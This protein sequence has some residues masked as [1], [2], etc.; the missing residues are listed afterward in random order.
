M[1]QVIV[2]RSPNAQRN[3]VLDHLIGWSD[4]LSVQQFIRTLGFTPENGKLALLQFKDATFKDLKYDFEK[5]WDWKALGEEMQKNMESAMDKALMK[6][7]MSIMPKLDPKT[8]GHLTELDEALALPHPA[9]WHPMARQV[10]R[11][12]IMHVGPTNSGKTYHA[13]RALAGARHGCYA[14]PLRLLATEIFLRF[15]RGDI[16]PV[17]QDPSLKHP[18]VCNLLTG[19]DVKVLDE[20]AGLM[21][22]T[23]EML[24]LTQKFDVVVIDEIQMLANPERGNGWTQALVGLNAEEIHLCGEESAVELVQKLVEPT[25]DEIIVHRYDR[26][27]PLQMAPESLRGELKGVKPGDCVVAFSRNQIFAIKALIE[28]RTGLRCAVAYG[29]LPPEVRVEQASKF[30]QG[31]GEYPVLVA[32]DAIGMGLNLKIKRIIFSTVKKWNGFRDEVVPLSEIKQIAGRAGRY[33]MHGPDSIGT[34]TVLSQTDYRV[35]ESAMQTPVPN[36]ET[37]V[38]AA[39]SAALSKIHRC[40]P[41]NAGLGQVYHLLLNLATCEEPF[42]LADYFKLLDA[43]AIVDEACPN[44][45]ISTRATLTQTPV[46]WKI[47]EAIPMFKDMLLPFAAGMKVDAET[48]FGKAGLLLVLEDVSAAKEE[49]LA[50]VEAELVKEEQVKTNGRPIL[51][52][53]E[54]ARR[55]EALE[56]LHKMTCVYLWLS[57]RYPIAFYQ[58]DK[59][60]EIKHASELGIQFCLEMIQSE[61]AKEMEARLEQKEKQARELE[62]RKPAR[63]RTGDSPDVLP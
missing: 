23:V 41:A 33:G 5:I 10:H 11:K 22:C 49:H 17:G 28:E 3:A 38:I 1:Q 34:V 47:P 50:R 57:Y 54:A 40:L 35:V 19:E 13:L 59:V 52:V 25:G 15:N 37:A 36:L 18:R 39:D 48:I 45:S 53:R 60:K 9:E 58:Q 2:P 62:R 21:S 24:P 14:G 43:A 26:L 8:Y 7:F 31:D 55:L 4:R 12:I 61:R 32:S 56:L 51:S 6:R 29:K 27:T 44:L 63:G 42:V 20:D 16:A 30:N 46:P